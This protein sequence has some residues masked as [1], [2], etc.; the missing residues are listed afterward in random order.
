MNKADVLR[1]RLGDLIEFTDQPNYNGRGPLPPLPE[2]QRGVVME[3]TPKGGVR[4]R[5]RS[6][7]RW[8]P[9]HL[10]SQRLE[11][12]TSEKSYLSH[13]AGEF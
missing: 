3:V 13:Q 10:V 9:Y 12:N 11:T 2:Y 8:I 4:V 5:G 7:A 6:G 1:F